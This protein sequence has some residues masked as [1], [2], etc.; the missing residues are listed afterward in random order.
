M[1]VLVVLGLLV[2]LFMSKYFIEESHK[3]LDPLP[4]VKWGFVNKT[5]QLVIPAK[6]EDIGQVGFHSFWEKQFSEGLCVVKSQNKWGYIDH[7]GEWR[8][9]P[10]FDTAKAFHEGLAYA[11]LGTGCGYINPTGEMVITLKTDPIDN[12]EGTLGNFGDL[13][14]FSNDRAVV[15]VGA[16]YGY[17]DKS[18]NSVIPPAYHFAKRFS[19]GLAAI[20]SS[21][22]NLWGYIDIHG[23][24]VIPPIYQ[25]ASSFHDGL[26]AV[27]THGPRRSRYDGSR[28]NALIDQSGRQVFDCSGKMCDPTYFSEG[29]TS[30]EIYSWMWR[31]MIGVHSLNSWGVVDRKGNVLFE[32]KYPVA[33]YREGLALKADNATHHVGYV[34]RHGFWVVKPEFDWPALD[35]S[36]GLAAVAKNGKAGYIDKLGKFVIQPIYATSGRVDVHPQP[37]SEGLAAVPVLIK[38]DTTK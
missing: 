9:E 17:I 23:K 20:L 30:A 1:L 6:F 25:Q 14:D 13:R 19:E 32:T 18:G 38:S 21:T 34:N 29:L 16:L 35:F 28:S 33:A 3:E 12:G 22:T 7:S 31:L 11:A 10:R 15:R 36:E 4:I 24:D 5:G 37:F 26:A 2:F 27:D 8:I